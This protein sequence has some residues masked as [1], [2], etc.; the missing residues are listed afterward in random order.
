MKDHPRRDG[1]R[2]VTPRALLR[3]RRASMKDHPRRDGYNLGL[4][5]EG[6]MI[7]PQ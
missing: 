5:H 2:G 6:T 7:V 3:C 1:Y 4:M